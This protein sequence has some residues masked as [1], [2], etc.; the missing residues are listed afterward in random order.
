L[1]NYDALIVEPTAA[2]AETLSGLINESG[3][4]AFQIQTLQELIEAFGD[5]VSHTPRRKVVII[6]YE[7]SQEKLPNLFSWIRK[8]DLKAETF[9]FLIKTTASSE[10][11]EKLAE[12]GIRNFLF[13]PVKPLQLLETVAQALSGEEV[14]PQVTHDVHG[15]VFDTGRLLQDPRPLRVLA[16]DD[17]KDN[18]FLVK[19]YLA[20]L[21]YRITFADNGRI[22]LEKFKTAQFDIIL[23]DLQMPEMDGYTAT[24]LIR[25]WESSENLVSTPVIAVS[26]HDNEAGSDQFR[27]AQFSGY[28]VKPIS[29]NQ[30][31]AAILDRT[32]NISKSKKQSNGAQFYL[33]ETSNNSILELEKQIA[34]LAPQ[35]LKSRCQELEEFKNLLDKENFEKLQTLG[36]RLKGNAKSYGFEELGKLGS[37]LE[38]AAMNRDVSR[39]RTLIVETERYL[40]QKTQ[41]G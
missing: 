21:P 11:I 27:K 22:A 19:A 39:I 26:A 1:E 9:V 20:T 32:Q 29:P 30:L 15:S 17:S 40:T 35:Y 7:H 31:R 28:L 37:K 25:E 14:K 10:S 8:G 13:K 38:E 24:R 33:M 12:Y 5:T 36:H 16:V 23:M 3:G 41:S 4:R 34:D 6:D 2:I 18:Q